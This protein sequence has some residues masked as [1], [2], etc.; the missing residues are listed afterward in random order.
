MSVAHPR[1]EPVK[2][3]HVHPL[4][5][6]QT[7]GALPRFDV[8]VSAVVPRETDQAIIGLQVEYPRA[9]RRS[10]TIRIRSSSQSGLK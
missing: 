7:M 1:K 4:R 2:V 5:D 8:E 3:L 6:V 9:E 10:R